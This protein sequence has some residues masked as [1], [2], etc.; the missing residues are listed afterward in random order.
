M[1]ASVVRTVDEANHQ[2][3]S[4]WLKRATSVL[5]LKFATFIE[6]VAHESNQATAGGFR[7][8]LI[9]RTSDSGH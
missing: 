4:N 5:I 9:M 1:I 3:L 8:V 7:P 2:I 6:A